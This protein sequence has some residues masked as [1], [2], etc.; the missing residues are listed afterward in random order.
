MLTMLALTLTASADCVPRGESIVIQD[1]LMRVSVDHADDLEIQVESMT[2]DDR[3]PWTSGEGEV[4]VLDAETL[5]EGEV[6]EGYFVYEDHI[7][8]RLGSTGLTI[9]KYAFEIAGMGTEV[10]VFMT[11]DFIFEDHVIFATSIVAG[12]LEAIEGDIPE[13]AVQLI[14]SPTCR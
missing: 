7:M 6:R 3:V 1:D 10:L 5:E 4:L 11:S 9:E 13:G 14:P 12:P 8:M 2:A